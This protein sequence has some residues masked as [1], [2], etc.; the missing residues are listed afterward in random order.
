[1]LS[2]GINQT[3]D[4]YQTVLE[5]HPKTLPLHKGRE[6]RLKR[7]GAGLVKPSVEHA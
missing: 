2:A 3:V 5:P 4:I 7:H 1:M 6:P